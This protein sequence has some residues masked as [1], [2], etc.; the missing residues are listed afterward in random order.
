MSKLQ[1]MTNMKLKALFPFTQSQHPFCPRPFLWLLWAPKEIKVSTYKHSDRP[2]SSPYRLHS[3]SHRYRNVNELCTM[4]NLFTHDHIFKPRLLGLQLRAHSMDSLASSG[5]TTHTHL[6]SRACL[7]L[8]LFLFLIYLTLY[9][10]ATPTG[11]HGTYF[12]QGISR[13]THTY[14]TYEHRQTKVTAVSI[15]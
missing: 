8:F 12:F 13:R 14:I 11:S 5:I 4:P 2:I 3:L 6:V 15:A 9:F 1:R 10:K 7:L